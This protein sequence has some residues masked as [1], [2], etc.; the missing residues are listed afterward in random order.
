MDKVKAKR[1]KSHTRRV[2]D[3][4]QT[5]QWRRGLIFVCS[6]VKFCLNLYRYHG[7]SLSDAYTKAVA[8]YRALCSEHHIATVYA[9]MEAEHYGSTFGRSEN[10]ISV[11]LQKKALQTW[12]RK[13]ELDEG[14]LAARKR[15]KALVEKNHG[16]NQWTKG[17]EYVRLWQEGIRPNYSPA[18]TEPVQIDNLAL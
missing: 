13:E 11:E 3:G 5:S 10:E 9:A 8:Q 7:I 16:V 6:A 4:L 1:K 2:S 12:S 18:L 17:E 14:A 15:W